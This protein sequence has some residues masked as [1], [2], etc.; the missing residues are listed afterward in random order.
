MKKREKLSK[1]DLVIWKTGEGFD[2]VLPPYEKSK[3]PVGVV[4]GVTKLHNPE[5]KPTPGVMVLW[6]TYKQPFWSPTSMVEVVSNAK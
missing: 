1:G 5:G 3:E 6:S 4:V 2:L